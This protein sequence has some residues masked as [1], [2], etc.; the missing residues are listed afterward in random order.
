M[1]RPAVAVLLVIL[2]L[3]IAG[4]AA[5]DAANPEGIADRFESIN[6]DPQFFCSSP[7]P[8]PVAEASDATLILRGCAAGKTYRVPRGGTI[9]ID[10]ASGGR[11][12]SGAV[13]HAL[14]VSDRWILQTVVP[15]KTIGDPSHYVIVDYVAIYRGA[16]RG[17]VTVSALYRVC[18]SNGCI[19]TSRWEAFVQVI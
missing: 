12:D 6:D 10:L 14:T 15:P 13:F 16:R 8:A 7:D 19:D 5:I 4:A 17:I 3:A 18:I 2:L 11:L 9:A 1:A